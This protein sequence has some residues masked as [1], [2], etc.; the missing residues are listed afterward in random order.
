MLTIRQSQLDIFS[1]FRQKI[2]EDRMVDII[3]HDYPNRYQEAGDP[4][5]RQLIRFAVKRG[6]EFGVDTETSLAALVELMIAFGQE[7]ELSPNRA[8]ARRMMANRAAP[9]DL[10]LHLMRDRMMTTSHGRP[11]VAHKFPAAGN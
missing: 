11:V 5:V 9:P 10:R 3:A 4:A 6:G 7:F 1:S 8:W 2:W